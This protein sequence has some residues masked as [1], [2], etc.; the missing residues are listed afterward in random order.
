MQSSEFVVIDVA[1]VVCRELF[2]R[3]SKLQLSANKLKAIEKKFAALRPL[4]LDSAA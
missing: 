3:A 1:V 4:L 2:E